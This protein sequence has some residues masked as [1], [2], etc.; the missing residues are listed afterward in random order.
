[1]LICHVV[2]GIPARPHSPRQLQSSHVDEPRKM[3]ALDIGEWA[4]LV[5]NEHFPGAAVVRGVPAAVENVAKAE[6]SFRW[7]CRR[8]TAGTAK[9]NAGHGGRIA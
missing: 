2:P 9:P 3:P 6:E 7:S 4:E 5:Q 8:Q 1:M